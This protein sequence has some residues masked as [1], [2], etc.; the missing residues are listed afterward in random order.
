[1]YG[2]HEIPANP[3]AYR[4]KYIKGARLPHLWIRPITPEI[5]ETIPPVDLQHVYEFSSAEKEVRQYSTLDLCRF[6]SFT[7]IINPS[8]FRSEKIL[9]WLELLN[10]KQ[11][12]AVVP[13]RVA[14]LGVDFD[15]VFKDQA[16]E[17]L[18]E[19]GLGDGK[20]GGVLVRPDQ[21]IVLVLEENVSVQQ[22]DSAIY[23]AAGWQATL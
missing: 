10:N 16:K 19:F 23:E 12:K 2:S 7:L 21:H 9:K 4:P 20:C 17:W 1:V 6:D 8:T 5:C 15:I 13:L 14:I 11:G 18:D 22:L 3:S